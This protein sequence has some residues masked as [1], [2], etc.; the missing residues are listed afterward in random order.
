MKMGMVR[1][2]LT[3]GEAVM[4]SWTSTMA[5]RS[6]REGQGVDLKEIGLKQQI[7]KGVTLRESRHALRVNASGAGG[8]TQSEL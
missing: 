1:G 5:A 2:R 3:S 7:Q 6:L 4:I 8:C